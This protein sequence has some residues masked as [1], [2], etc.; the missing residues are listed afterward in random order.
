MNY[1]DTF[2]DQDEE[3]VQE[4]SRMSLLDG[5]GMI[6]VVFVVV[7]FLA[8]YIRFKELHPIIQGLIVSAV[9]GV[10]TALIIFLIIYINLEYY[11]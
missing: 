6:V 9:A 8:P 4:F 2:R 11:A 7:C 5:L 3:D 1:P 10:A